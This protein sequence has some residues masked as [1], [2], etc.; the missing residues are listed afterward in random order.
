[1]KDLNIQK[2]V[3]IFLEEHKLYV[4]YIGLQ[5]SFTYINLLQEAFKQRVFKQRVFEK[6]SRGQKAL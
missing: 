2:K 5:M 3:I 6:Y 4:A 1:M